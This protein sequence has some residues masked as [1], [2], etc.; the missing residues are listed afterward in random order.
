[1][2]VLDLNQLFNWRAKN[3][4]TLENDTHMRT[5]IFNIADYA[6]K[7]PGHWITNM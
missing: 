5:S 1:M 3:L 6:Q 2:D 4:R 7:L